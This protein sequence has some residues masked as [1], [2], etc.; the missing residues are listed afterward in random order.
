MI[1]WLVSGLAGR[2][3]DW[4]FAHLFDCSLGWLVVLF[5]SLVGCFW[6][7]ARFFVCFN[8]SLFVWIIR[9]IV[10]SFLLLAV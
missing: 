6:L 1:G 2:S 4:L 5:V 7:I 8:K 9:W 3:I 10:A